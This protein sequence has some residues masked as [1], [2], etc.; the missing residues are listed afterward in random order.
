MKQ[1][2][3]HLYK[4]KRHVLRPWAAPSITWFVYFVSCLVT[5][6]HNCYCVLYSTRSGDK[7]PR[8]TRPCWSLCFLLHANALAPVWCQAPTDVLMILTPYPT[9]SVRLY[10]GKY[11][12]WVLTNA[13][14]L[15]EL[16]RSKP[17][18][19]PTSGVCMKVLMVCTVK[20]KLYP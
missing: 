8:S 12:V 4:A 2:C 15:T 20:K 11:Y 1:C 16:I 3:P 7:P 17:A 14:N 10:V 19:R 6:T 9:L 18:L 13:R 5:N